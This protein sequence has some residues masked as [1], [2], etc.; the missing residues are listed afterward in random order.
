VKGVLADAVAVLDVAEGAGG[1]KQLSY[2]T[3]TCLLTLTRITHL[4]SQWTWET[5]K[6]GPEVY[7]Q[8]WRIRQ[9]PAM[10]TPDVSDVC[11]CPNA[12]SRI[13][14]RR[15]Y[16]PNDRSDYYIVE[17]V[18]F[19]LNDDDPTD[20]TQEIYEI[21]QW[22]ILGFVSPAELER[23]EN[24]QFSIE[25]EVEVVA[26]AETFEQHRA[27]RMRNWRLPSEVRASLMLSGLGL[28]EGAPTRGR[29]RSRGRRARSR[30]SGRGRSLTQHRLEMVENVQRNDEGLAR[31][32]EETGRVIPETESEDEIE[33]EE[34]Q[35]S[36]GLMRSAFVTSSALPVSPA[37][38]RSSLLLKEMPSSSEMEQSLNDIIEYANRL[39]N[40][41]RR[42][43]QGRRSTPLAVR[44]QPDIPDSNVPPSQQ[45]VSQLL[46][47]KPSNPMDESLDDI[48]K[49]SKASRRSCQGRRSTPQPEIPDSDVLVPDSQ[50]SIASRT[51]FPAEAFQVSIRGTI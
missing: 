10:V 28:P 12:R 19:G 25:V 23:Y 47:S 26:R 11:P 17:V 8:L 7:N 42:D 21:D 18:Y 27:R 3:R 40:T 20:E 31:M 39:H 37:Q 33:D 1:A 38:R 44:D 14:E 24:Q 13:I 6:P 41:S 22:E 45:R 36:P 9:L 49:A 50:P 34:A 15:Q 16:T 51:V 4:T 30:G 5:Y 43:R 48:I 46:P 32:E 2:V 35:A 29:G